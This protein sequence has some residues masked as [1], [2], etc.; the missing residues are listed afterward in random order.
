MKLSLFK[1]QLQFILFFS[2]FMLFL[3]ACDKKTEDVAPIAIPERLE[4]S[5]TS[6]SISVDETTSFSLT[7]F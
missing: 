6:Q 4:I 5:P 2:V 7:F 3:S 1:N